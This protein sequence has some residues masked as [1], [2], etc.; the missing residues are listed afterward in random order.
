MAG[1]GGGDAARRSAALADRDARALDVACQ[2]GARFAEASEADLAA[3][4]RGLRS[5]CTRSLRRHSAT[6]AFIERIQAL[7]QSTRRAGARHP[8]RVH[9]HGPRAGPQCGAAK[10]PSDLNGTYRWVLTQKDA[11]KVGDPET[12]YPHVNT[13]TLKD[14][15]LEGGCFGAKGGTYA[16][17]DDRITFDSV[18]YDDE[19][20]GDVRQWTR[21]A[22]FTSRPS[23]RWIRVPRSSASTSPGRRS[24]EPRSVTPPRRRGGSRRRGAFRRPPGCRLRAPLRAPRPGRPDP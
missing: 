2:A 10:A 19:C 9:R 16:V 22:T 12:N 8:V 11:D 1:G 23:R 4:A 18:E 17:E 14:G 15:H 13:I 5:L 24:T 20:H 21:R 3:L 6:K 7:K